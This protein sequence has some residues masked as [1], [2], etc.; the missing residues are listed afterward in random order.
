MRNALISL[1]L[2]LLMSLP[3]AAQ[4]LNGSDIAKKTK[5]ALEPS[6]SSIRR[7]TI[8]VNQGSRLT[9]QWTGAQARTTEDGAHYM[10]TA[11]L[12]PIQAKGMAVLAKQ[13]DNQ[14]EEIWTYIPTLARTVKLSPASGFAPLFG[15]DFTFADLA[16]WN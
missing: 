3:A 2:V 12:A 6:V 7:L 16:L 5:A 8:S 15:S 9:A 13:Q 11:V 4:T 14:S 10:V 1:G